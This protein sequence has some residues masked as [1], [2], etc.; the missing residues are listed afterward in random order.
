MRA[1]L[2]F[3]EAPGGVGFS[4]GP[5]NNSDDDVVSDHLSA[6]SYF[7]ARFPTQKKND[8]YLAGHGY[9]GILAP[10]LAKVILDRNQ[11]PFFTKINFKGNQSIKVRFTARQSMHLPRRM[12]R[13]RRSKALLLHLRVSVQPQLYD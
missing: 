9:A 3:L 10:K 6:L 11:S 2:L 12:L 8:L 4:V 7:F 5:V 13:W 1:N